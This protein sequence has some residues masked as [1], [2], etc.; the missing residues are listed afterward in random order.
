M[1]SPQTLTIPIRLDLGPS[2]AKVA[3][4]HL[5]AETA[6]I[7]TSI[8]ELLGDADLCPWCDGDIDH[9]VGR[10]FTVDHATDCELGQLVALYTPQE[11][12]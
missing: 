9:P 2:A 8:A 7:V 6:G 5:L 1:T 4:V 12:A 11:N 10:P 3:A